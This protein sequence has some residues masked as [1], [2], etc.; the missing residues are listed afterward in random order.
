MEPLLIG[1][2]SGTTSTKAILFDTAGRVL[3]EFSKGYEFVDSGP[4]HIEQN[5]EDWWRAAADGI[6]HLAAAAK[7]KGTVRALAL[8]T[9]GATVVPVDKGYDPMA[10]AVTWLDKRASR[11]VERLSASLPPGFALERTGM[12][13]G[14]W[15]LLGK[16]AWWR[17]ERP[18]L[19]ASAAAFAQVNDFLIHRLTGVEASDPSNAVIAGLYNLRSGG[20]AEELLALA[21]VSPARLAPIVRSGSAVGVV[22]PEVAQALGLPPGVIV[23]SGG[24]DQYCGALGCGVVE[25]GIGM[26]SCGTAWVLLV[27]TETLRMDPQHRVLSGVHT[28][29]GRF[30]L[31]AAMSNGGIA[32]DRMR[33]IVLGPDAD[34]INRGELDGELAA[35]DSR[36]VPIIF[37]PHLTGAASPW[38]EPSPRASLIGLEPQDGRAEVMFAVMQ[39]LCLETRCALDVMR[40][41]GI[42]V[43]CLRI[44]GG[45]AKSPIWQQLLADV[46][47]VEVR[48]PSNTEAACRGAAVL[49]GVAAGL[50]P[51]AIEGCRE[52]L[53]AEEVVAPRRD[54]AG[55]YGKLLQAHKAALRG[56]GQAFSL[57]AELREHLGA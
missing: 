24:H 19:F 39:G 46:C 41:L 56:L 27:A 6:R 29:E 12:D 11:Q 55:R 44:M 10:N 57:L 9:Q 33:Q 47:Q 1:I 13:L 8:S 20:W 32:W 37:L 26:V 53:P 34:A 3:A 2:D 36:G 28:A 15:G 54:R 50:F 17:D 52:M 51:S 23:A 42:E 30:G 35:L 31:M 16:I 4:G 21:G 7:G 49:A 45:A 5:A 40:E 22:R 43:G 38:H 25:E 48:V 18:E 14:A